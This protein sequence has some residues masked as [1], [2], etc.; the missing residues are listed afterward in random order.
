MMH[1]PAIFALVLVAALSTAAAESRLVLGT[2]GAV[3]TTD[4]SNGQLNIIRSAGDK[5]TS[6][7]VPF[8]RDAAAT[9]SD[10]TLMWDASSPALFVIW[11]RRSNHGDQILLA[12]VDSKGKWSEPVAITTESPVRRAGLQAVMSRSS[13]HRATLIHAAWWNMGID[14]AAEYALVAFEGGE[15]VSTS[16]SALDTLAGLTTQAFSSEP[17]KEVL[18]P[19]LAMARS[20]NGV[21]I[22]FGEAGS[23]AVTRMK[24]TPGP[25]PNARIWKPVGRSAERLPSA[26]LASNS[27]APVRAM[28]SKGRVVLYAPEDNFRFV[29]YD[30]SG[31]SPERVIHLDDQITNEQLE[32]ELRVTIEQL[33]IA[34]NEGTER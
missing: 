15:H 12:R 8:T 27:S 26:R 34:E 19:P 1:K 7:L 28:I 29:I 33:G 6:M 32:H 14:P 16:A 11:H 2:D 30:E 10:A 9:E 18:H 25:V 17:M 24:I 3:Y 23:T 20:A 4:S 13:D 21:E 5:R 31:W 22:L